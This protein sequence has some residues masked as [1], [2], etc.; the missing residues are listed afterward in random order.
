MVRAPTLYPK[1]KEP[2]CRGIQPEKALQV[3]DVANDAVPDER[4][5]K[6]FFPR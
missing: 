1:H 5:T 3:G 6:V 2:G 4:R